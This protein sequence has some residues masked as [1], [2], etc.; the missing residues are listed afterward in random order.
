[1]K[2]WAGWVTLG[3]RGFGEGG[4]IG[5]AEAGDVEA[6]E[7]VMPTKKAARGGGRLV[8]GTGAG[9]EAPARDCSGIGKPRIRR[10][11]QIEEPP[12]PRG[13]LTTRR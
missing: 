4:C 2:A 8:I 12:E 9:R 7:E 5:A 3:A 6:G 13:L 11:S 10:P 1:M